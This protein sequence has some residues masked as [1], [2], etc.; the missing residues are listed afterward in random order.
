MRLIDKGVLNVSCSWNYTSL[1]L[2]RSY[3]LNRNSTRSQ[4]L[5][6]QWE[7]FAGSQTQ[8]D[9]IAFPA[10]RS[11]L[12]IQPLWKEMTAVKSS[13]CLINHL[14]YKVKR[15][16]L[17]TAKTLQIGNVLWTAG[18]DKSVSSDSISCPHLAEAKAG[19]LQQSR[20]LLSNQQQNWPPSSFL[21]CFRMSTSWSS[22]A[23]GSWWP[24]WRDTASAAWASTY[25]WPPSACSGA[26]SCRASGTW[27]MA[28]SKWT[29]SSMIVFSAHAAFQ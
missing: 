14:N 26:S 7:H 3:A 29:S 23:S 13:N 19:L 6:E 25:S 15:I 28:R 1:N 17:W 16:P 2:L 21:Q 18:H 11:W 5:Q 20:A 27:I 12:T 4:T 10:N 22:L 8:C 24:S 9:L